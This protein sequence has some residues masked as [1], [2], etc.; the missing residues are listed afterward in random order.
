MVHEGPIYIVEDD[1]EVRSSLVL[2]L[3][4]QRL[5]AR[6]FIQAEDFL[7]ELALLQPG[8][9]LV[10]FR[11]PGMSGIELLEAMRRRHC[12]WPAVM[13]S[14]HGDIAV[15]VRAIKLG[16]IDFLQKP[17]EE[18]DLMAA[19]AESSRKLADAVTKSRRSL[20]RA[21]LATALSPR[22]REVFDGVIAG[23]TSKAMAADLDL[24]P[25]TVESYRLTM[26][27]KLG[28]RSLH[29]LLALTSSTSAIE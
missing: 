11:M 27:A 10:D 24:S 13:I 5:E 23:K 8:I 3:R 18:D 21:S 19:I 15:A 20:A 6:P 28:A 17:F 26:M 9:V 1:R 2:L 22:E 4:S 29:D 14:G 7:D 25:R 16:A 12:F